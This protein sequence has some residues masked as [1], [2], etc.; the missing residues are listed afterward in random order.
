MVQE[1]LE[2]SLS[3]QKYYTDQR[4]RPLEFFIGDDAHPNL[5]IKIIF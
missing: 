5:L 4:R 2:T 1:R 3:R